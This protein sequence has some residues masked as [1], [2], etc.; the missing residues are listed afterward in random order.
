MKNI[1]NIPMNAFKNVNILKSICV[2][3]HWPCEYTGNGSVGTV[4]CRKPKDRN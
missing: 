3:S 1:I 2:F 4:E